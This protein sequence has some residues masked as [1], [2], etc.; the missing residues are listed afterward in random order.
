MSIP[1]EIAAKKAKL[2]A[3]RP[4][5][6]ETIAALD[7]WF[8]VELTYTSNA[9]EGN[10]L[11]RSETAIVLEKGITVSGKPLKDHLEATGHLEAL[12]Y[13]RQLAAT[14][15]P[16]RELDIRNLH[17]LVMQGVSPDDA[18]A[19]SQHQRFISGSDIA[20]PS[21]PEIGPLMQIFSDSL[22][23]AA[24]TPEVAFDARERSS[25]PSTLSPMATAAPR[26]C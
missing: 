26:A 25:S 22:A 17:R 15:N 14:T 19:Y 2:D 6:T 10:T 18:G 23:T 20:L 7:R 16:I 9:L 3:L 12:G 5:A 1:A 24:P 11:T 21:P 8:D 4:L 13:M